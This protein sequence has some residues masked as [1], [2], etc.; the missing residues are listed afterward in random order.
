MQASPES[1][2]IP[3]KRAGHHPD[4]GC[5]QS[6]SSYSTFCQKWNR[7]GE[8]SGVSLV[9]RSFGVHHPSLR[10]ART[11]RT[12]LHHRWHQ[13]CRDNGALNSFIHLLTILPKSP[14]VCSALFCQGWWGLVNLVLTQYVWHQFVYLVP[15]L[16]LVLSVLRVRGIP[17]RLPKSCN[18]V[19]EWNS[20]FMGCT[21]I[22]SVDL[23]MNNWLQVWPWLVTTEGKIYQS[24]THRLSVSLLGTGIV[25]YNVHGGL[26]CFLF[27][28]VERAVLWIQRF[29]II[30]CQEQVRAN[31]SIPTVGYFLEFYT[32][33][34]GPWDTNAPTK[35]L[36]CSEGVGFLLHGV[37]IH[38]ICWFTNE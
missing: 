9:K 35:I 24:R 15:I 1:Q 10:E 29:C 17:M 19:K 31:V 36:Q 32:C 26:S 34:E 8:R 28:L 12:S 5:L 22:K 16:V 30:Y 6:G 11:L 2:L 7:N 3:K 13:W 37:Y 14:I 18:A 38:K 21:F 25:I 4:S 33:F 20:F 27:Q 23:P